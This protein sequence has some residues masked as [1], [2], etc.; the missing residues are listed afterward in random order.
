[1][2][3]DKKYIN[4]YTISMGIAKTWPDGTEKHPVGDSDSKNSTDSTKPGC[5]ES[6]E[7]RKALSENDLRKVDS[8]RQR[9]VE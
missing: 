6:G 3:L 4:K 7:S 2:L 1:M 8:T 9:R 5:V